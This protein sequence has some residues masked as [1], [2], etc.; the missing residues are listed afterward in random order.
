MEFGTMAN[1]A[2]PLVREERDAVSNYLGVA[3]SSI[4]ERTEAFC[5][6]RVIKIDDRA[7]AGWN[8]WSPAAGNTR[9]Q[10]AAAAGLTP[11]QVKRLKLKWAFGFEGDLAAFSQPTILDHTIF[12]GSASGQVQAI[13]LGSGCVKWAFQ[14]DAAVRAAIV[15]VPTGYRHT[16]LFGDTN[17]W[18][19]AV[20][21]ESGKLFWKKK[22]EPHES[23]R[24]TA[25]AVAFEDMV[26]VPTAS[27]EEARTTNPEYPCCTFRG[28]VTAYRIKDGEQRWKTYLISEKAKETAKNQWGPSGAGIWA[29]PTLDTKRGLLYVTTGDNYSA[30]AT[31][32]SDAVV[33][34]E[35]KSGKVAWSK[36]TTPGDVWNT[37]CSQ[38]NSCG[39]PDFDYGS[40]V[41]LEKPGDG[42]ELLL[43]GQKSGVVYALDPDKKGEIVWQARVGKGGVNGGVQW[44]M[45]SDG[46]RVYAATSDIFRGKKTNS[47]PHDPG[48]APLDPKQGGGLTALR[49]AN[50]EKA[51]FAEPIVC[52]PNAKPGCS[53]AQA[54]A[55]TAIPGVVFSGSMDGHLR[56]YSA[57]EGKILWDFDTIREFST[58]NGVHASGGSLSGPGPV[59]VGGIVLVNSG[60]SRGGGT[61]GNVLLA[62][63]PEN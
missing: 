42:R 31:P 12:V 49:L 44:G 53:P 41:M 38:T 9:Y 61:P 2:T 13:D 58:V 50:G 18:F 5:S 40:S 15:A 6:D 24:V 52:G 39:G 16:L 21:A 46:Q 11:D 29:A 37:A 48:A 20:E 62:F 7:R 22:P 23:A 4:T 30:P 47:D 17:G 34:L 28:S 26:Y 55:V 3:S 59:V 25:A 8:G 33:A 10:P 56:A 51:W 36:Q 63:A 1:V 43:A 57:E 60:Y 45:A 19:Y 14:A 32:M 54:G 35:L 27:W